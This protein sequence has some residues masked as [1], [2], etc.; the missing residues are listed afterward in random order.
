MLNYHFHT[1]L[2]LVVLTGI[3]ASAYLHLADYFP[4]LTGCRP[5][6]LINMST[7]TAT[8]RVIAYLW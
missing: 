3:P 8:A 2:D 1:C 6:Q 5:T 7:A 4:T